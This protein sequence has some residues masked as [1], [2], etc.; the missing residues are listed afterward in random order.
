MKLDTKDGKA[1][2]FET[3]LNGKFVGYLLISSFL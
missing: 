3:I 2:M 1:S